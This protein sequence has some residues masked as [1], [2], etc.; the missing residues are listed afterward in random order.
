MKKFTL[1]FAIA[2]IVLA[3]LS[4][5]FT[6]LGGGITLGT[7]VYFHN[8]DY[9]S[10]HKTGNPAISFKA[11]YELSLPFHLSPSL[12][13]FMP[14]ITEAEFSDSKQIVSAF[15]ADINGHYVFN[16]LDRFEL[17]GLAGMNITLLKNKWV[18]DMNDITSDSSTETLPGLNIGVGAYMKVAN[19]LDIFGE[20]KYILSK[21]D[22]FVLTAGVLLNI[23]WLK[24]NETSAF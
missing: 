23:D 24:K 18:Y 3:G 19:Q 7:G 17:Y 5:Q 10:S 13:L 1:T 15:L 12:S 4:A 8:E 2:F 22:Q 6:K 9:A 20:F 14:R 21:R 11:I 16:S